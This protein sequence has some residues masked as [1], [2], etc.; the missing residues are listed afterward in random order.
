MGRGVIYLFIYLL[1]TWTELLLN[2]AEISRAD[3]RILTVGRACARARAEPPR[4]LFFFAGLRE[5]VG[6]E[7]IRLPP[8]EELV[9]PKRLLLRRI[10]SEEELL[11]GRLDTRVKNYTAEAQ[12]S[13]LFLSRPPARGLGYV[14]TTII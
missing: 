6:P 10:H 5:P 9:Q 1:I 13:S 3:P 2:S 14:V 4:G 7:G 8:A 11:H 12:V